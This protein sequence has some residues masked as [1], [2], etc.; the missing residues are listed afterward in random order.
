MHRQGELSLQ[1]SEHAVCRRRDGSV[2]RTRVG[3]LGALLLAARRRQLGEALDQFGEAF[4][5]AL[6]LGQLVALLANLL[7]ELRQ[8]FLFLLL[9]GDQLLLLPILF[10]PNP[11]QLRLACLGRLS[12]AVQ[13]AEVVA[14]VD[15]QLAACARQVAVVAQLARRQVGIL[16]VEQYLELVLPAGDVLL[17]KEARHA[18][19]FPRDAAIEF[20]LLLLQR[21]QRRG[22]LGLAAGEGAQAIVEFADGLFGGLQFVAGVG[23]GTLLAVQFLLQGFDASVQFLQVGLGF[24]PCGR[25]DAGQRRDADAGEQADCRTSIHSNSMSGCPVIS[26]GWGRPMILNRDGATSSRAPVAATFALRPMYRNGTRFRVWAVWAGGYFVYHLFG[27]AVVGDDQ[28]FAADVP[29]RA[30]DP[31]DADVQGLDC[32]DG[33]RQIAGVADH[34]AIGVVADDGLNLR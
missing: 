21:G 15:Q 27:I 8:Q 16:V 12:E 6:Q 30:H 9:P 11:R 28:H 26:R 18:R 34:V 5:V 13:L 24:G 19:V 29:H 33:G 4:L 20:V 14:Q 10:R 31:A 1:L 25:V 22:G 2:P 23:L 32:L 3:G 17:V 7:R